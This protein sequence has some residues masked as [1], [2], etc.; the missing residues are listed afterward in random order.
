MS[1]PVVDRSQGLLAAGALALVALVA[2]AL[3]ARAGDPGIEIELDRER[4]VLRA[5]DVASGDE[6]PSFPVAMG[7]P[8]NPTP[9]G[10][11]GVDR[12]ILNPGWRPGDGARDAGVRNRPPSLTSPM[13]VAKI[14]FAKKGE[15]ALHGAGERLLLG[16]PVSSGCV[17]SDD[18]DLLALVAW[19]HRR[20]A[21]SEPAATPDGEVHR[22]FRRPVRIRVR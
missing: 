8:A 3:P 7:S 11:F 6:G 9:S 14:P 19:L 1:R 5:V 20:G 22:R 2:L 18:A 21:L 10:R 4:F 16:K 15:I 17:R 13:G 12:V